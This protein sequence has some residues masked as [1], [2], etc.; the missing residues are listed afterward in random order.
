M[1]WH[2]RMYWLGLCLLL[3]P[4]E[5]LAQDNPQTP[6]AS[7]HQTGLVV[8]LDELLATRLD[9]LGNC[10][11]PEGQQMAVRDMLF[12]ENKNIPW[13]GVD[14]ETRARISGDT[15]YIDYKGELGVETSWQI[16]APE[17]D[18]EADLDLDLKFVLIE[19]MIGLYWRET[20][21]HRTYR[22]GVFHFTGERLTTVCEGRGG[23]S[24]TH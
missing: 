8:D 13:S 10:E 18:P 20:F 24:V 5:V 23:I 9:P 11:T 12:I 15:L 4:F 17:I 2:I 3:C 6:T 1:N 14:G 21:Q 22:Q 7:A 19:G 16:I